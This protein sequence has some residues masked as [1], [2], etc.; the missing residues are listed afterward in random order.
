MSATATAL[1]PLSTLHS[2]E[3]R[4][5]VSAK[6]EVAD[7]VVTL[8]LTHPDGLRL[9]DWSPGSHIDLFLPNGAVRQYSLCG[10]RTDTRTYRI[11]VLR[12]PSSRGGS[13]YVHDELAVP[14][15]TSTS[16]PRRTTSSSPA[17]SASPRSSR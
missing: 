14:A 9:P 4:L 12:E 15:T 8:E 10:D 17:G 6:R 1:R 16:C 11:G 3:L 5:A 2:S 13:S 7:G